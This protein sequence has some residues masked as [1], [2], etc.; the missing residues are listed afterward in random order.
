L[1]TDFG[2]AIQAAYIDHVK[3]HLDWRDSLQ[4]TK[5][6]PLGAKVQSQN[7]NTHCLFESS[8]AK[9]IGVTKDTNDKWAFMEIDSDTNWQ[10]S[11]LDTSM[12][13]ETKAGS[14]EGTIPFECSSFGI[15]SLVMQKQTE[16]GSLRIKVVRNGNLL[17]EGSTTAPYGLVSLAGQC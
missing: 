16:D 12:K 14:G 15:Y 13:S 3:F 11:V 10:G 4:L 9:Q 5:T 2:D 6:H 17:K 8:F 7:C 1:I